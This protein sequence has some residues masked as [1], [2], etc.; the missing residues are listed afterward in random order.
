MTPPITHILSHSIF[1][2]N[3]VDIETNT[4]MHHNINLYV[5]LVSLLCWF[6]NF[7]NN[8]IFKLNTKWESR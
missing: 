2:N 1:T 7:F 6:T 5:K 3:H 8:I 4:G